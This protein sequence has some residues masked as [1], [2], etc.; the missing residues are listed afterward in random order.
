KRLRARA[1]RC[2]A[3]SLWLSGEYERSHGLNEES[4]A[5][6]REL[7]DDMG[8]AVLLHRLGISTLGY[9]E[10]PE[11]AR[12]LLNES[13]E[14][15]RPAG[16]ERGESEVL[17]GLGYVSEQEGDLE[18]A[19]ELFS[20]AA[21]L[22]AEVRFTWWEVAMLAAIAEVLSELDRLDMA[23]SP[24][25][26]HLELAREIGDRQSSVFGLVLIAFLAARRGDHGRAHLL[27]RAR[28]AA[29]GPRGGGPARGCRRGGGRSRAD[30]PVGGRAR[31]LP[32]QDHPCRRR[33]SRAG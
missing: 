26:R 17:G 22:A 8:I 12:E 2:Y 7:E 31:G 5:L 23:E 33:G 3:G 20:R 19:L 6:F 30:R 10:G 18:V 4:L 21:E 29:G 24:A 27:R 28:D 1:L 15:S 32:G 11:K 25:R 14:Q 9:L 16:W 13:L